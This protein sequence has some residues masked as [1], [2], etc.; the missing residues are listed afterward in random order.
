MVILIF[1]S[2]VPTDFPFFTRAQLLQP[3]YTLCSVW[4]CVNKCIFWDANKNIFCL[5]YGCEESTKEVNLQERF[6]NIQNINV[7]ND[8]IWVQIDK[9]NFMSKRF[10]NR[11][12][13][14]W[15]LNE[16]SHRITIMEMMD[17]SIWIWLQQQ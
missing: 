6:R 1:E 12:H 11:W 7:L 16:I 2:K 15:Y 8:F 13:L 9:K 17:S 3:I 4:M 5:L 14:C 10:I